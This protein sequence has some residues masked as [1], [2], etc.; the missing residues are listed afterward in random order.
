[1]V[2][3]IVPAAGI[4]FYGLTLVGLVPIS[5][6]WGS[7]ASAG[8]VLVFLGVEMFAAKG[9]SPGQTP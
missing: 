4:L 6:S 7:I 8:S 9:Q 5:Q 1:M 3:A 2:R